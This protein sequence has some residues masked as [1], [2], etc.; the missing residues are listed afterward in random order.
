MKFNI[1]TKEDPVLREK[2]KKIKDPLDKEIQELVSS[3]LETMR[4]SNGVGLAAPQVGKNLRLCVIEEGGE[5]Y[6]LIN[7]QI[8]AFS[9]TKICEEEGCLS[10]PGEFFQ[11]T[12]S[13]EVKVRFVDENGISRKIKAGGLLGRAFQ[14]EIDHL[15]GVLI[16]D[17][18]KKNRKSKTGPITNKKNS[19]TRTA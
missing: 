18:L 17:R 12:R 19:Q 7:P 4:E 14:H 6:I 13:E 16:T 1:R 3:M 10:F 5:T 2:N 15:D 9:K 8:T 11:I